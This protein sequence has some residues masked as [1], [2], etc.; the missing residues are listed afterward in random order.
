MANMDPWSSGDPSPYGGDWGA[1]GESSWNPA[2]GYQYSTDPYAT[3]E[4][5]QEYHI[6][7]VQ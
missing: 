6:L 7:H 3:H 1:P 2:G 4:V 5:F